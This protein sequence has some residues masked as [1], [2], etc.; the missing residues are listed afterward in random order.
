MADILADVIT[1]DVDHGINCSCMD[2]AAR[3]I[4]LQIS[5]ALPPDGRTTDTD[6]ADPTQDRLNAKARVRHVLSMVERNL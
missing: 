6:W 3:E 5:K 2:Q 4:R 1:L